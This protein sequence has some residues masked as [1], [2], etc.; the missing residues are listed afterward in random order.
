[1]KKTEAIYQN[2]T[3]RIIEEMEKGIIPWHKPWS[4]Y[5]IGSDD[6][7]I[8]GAFNRV[9]KKMYSHINQCLLEHDG[10][11]ATFKQWKDL[12]G[13]VRKGEKAEKV[14]GWFVSAQKVLDEDGEPVL[15]D[16]GNE[17]V[18]TWLSATEYSVFHISQVDGVEPLDLKPVAKVERSIEECEQVFVN[19]MTAESI[20]IKELAQNEAYYMP[21]KDCIRVPK[22]SQFK[23][24]EEFYSTLF[25]EMVHST[26]HV[27]RLAREGVVN[28]NKFGSQEYSKEEL[29]AEMGSAFLMNICGAEIPATFKNS[30]AYLQNWLTQLKNDKRLIVN[31]SAQAEKA[32][33]Y[34]LG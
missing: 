2:I 13:K 33:K 30:T 21:S 20:D 29:V 28:V 25:H 10:E 32:V 31:A 15:D 23:A 27:K 16:D 5:R 34:I 26:G 11:Y 17:K 7:I 14:L 8:Y 18:N 9:S 1:M 12:G 3:D 24:I 22:R 19:Y 4:A 6:T